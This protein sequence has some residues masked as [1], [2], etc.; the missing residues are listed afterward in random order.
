MKMRLGEQKRATRFQQM[1]DLPEELLFIRHLVHHGEGQGEIDPAREI[2]QGQR[3]RPAHPRFDALEQTNKTLLDL[4]AGQVVE[5]AGNL[6]FL[7]AG[8]S[9]P[10]VAL[11]RRAWKSLTRAQRQ[12]L[13]Q[14]A[15]PVLCAVETI[16]HVGG[17]GIRCMLA[18]IFLPLADTAPVPATR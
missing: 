13:E 7:D 10:V 1:S 9:T 4:S 17:G 2:L 18:E 3:I 15:Q 11:S 12:L 5:F 16:E 14:H 6:L 8:G